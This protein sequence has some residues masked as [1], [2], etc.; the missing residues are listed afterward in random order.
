MR[1]KGQMMLALAL[2]A[3]NG[4]IQMWGVREGCMIGPTLSLDNVKGHGQPA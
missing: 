2:A 4:T 3:V 1:K